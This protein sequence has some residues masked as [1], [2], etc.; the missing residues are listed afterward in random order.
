MNITF[1]PDDITL[2]QIGLYA[3]ISFMIVTVLGIFLY[4]TC[5]KKYKL[6]WFEKNLLETAKEKQEFGQRYV[7]K[8]KMKIYFWNDLSRFF[9]SFI[10]TFAYNLFVCSHET[11]LSTAGSI[12]YNIDTVDTTSLRSSNRSPVSVNETFWVPGNPRNS[13]IYGEGQ[14]NTSAGML[15]YPFFFSV[16]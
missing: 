16:S 12:Q 7:Q 4:I 5:S 14:A 1:N 15:L 13:G 8:I 9:S 6:N 11:L 10:H 2:P 3:A